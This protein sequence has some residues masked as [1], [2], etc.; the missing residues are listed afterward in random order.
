METNRSSAS[1]QAP[2]PAE[3]RLDSWKEIAVYLNRGVTT[4]QRWERDEG[5]PVHRQQHDA[6]GSVYAYKS[7][8]ETW[9]VKRAVRTDADEPSHAATPVAPK[10]TPTSQLYPYGFVIG[11]LLAGAAIGALVQ[12]ASRPDVPKPVRRL[13]IVPPSGAP[14]ELSGTDRTLTITADGSRIVY[15]GGAGGTRLFVR[16]LDQRDSPAIAGV[17][18]PRHPFTSPDGRWTGFFD[19]NTLQNVPISGCS[20]TT[21]V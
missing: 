8:L 3:E 14:M 2:G 13:T 17:G 10:R 5:L 16:P 4:V 12:R 6:L 21:L 19:G 1:T 20:P 11:A 7:E 9:R 15:V 18:S